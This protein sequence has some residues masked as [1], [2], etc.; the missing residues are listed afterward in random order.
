MF[1][2]MQQTCVR[3]AMGLSPRSMDC[4]RRGAEEAERDFDEIAGEA[5]RVWD[6]A[7]SAIEVEADDERALRIFYSNFYHTLIKPSDWNGESFYYDDEE[8]FVLDF[9]TLWD[10]YK[11]Q[12]P[13]LFTLYPDM[14]QKITRTILALSLIHI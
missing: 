7:L 8:A 14:A 12:M 2:C 4:A 3:L 1:E 9:A 5:S 13:L 11:T 10:Q 6:E